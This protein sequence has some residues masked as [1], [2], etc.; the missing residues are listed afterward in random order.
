[1]RTENVKTDLGTKT[2][3]EKSQPE[4]LQPKIHHGGSKIKRK[5]NYEK[6]QKS[7]IGKESLQ[8]HSE[9]KHM[10]LNKKEIPGN[11]F[12]ENWHDESMIMKRLSNC[13]KYFHGVPVFAFDPEIIEYERKELS[14][15]NLAFSHMLHHQVV[16]YEAFLAM[17][18]RPNNFYCVHL[19]VKASDLI[20][21]T[22]ERLINCYSNKITTGKIFL[23]DKKES[24]DVR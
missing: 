3:R 5:S 13:E 19:D 2:I 18:F 8:K 16:I 17:Y 14:R 9:S 21:K 11:F 10:H 22:V 1:M 23:L 24:L 15:V 20:R 12:H 7:K 4:K 6:F